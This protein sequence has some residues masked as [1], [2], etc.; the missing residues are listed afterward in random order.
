M[1]NPILSIVIPVFNEADVLPAFLPEIAEY[2]QSNDFVLI[3]VD[4]ASTDESAKLLAG[5]CQQSN[6]TL[7]RHKVNRGYGGALKTGIKAC[8]T[9]YVVTMDADGQH[10]PVDA[11]RLLEFGLAKGADMVVGRRQ[12]GN[13]GLYRAIGRKMIRLLAG[14]LV[15]L[16]IE[17][18]NSGMKLYRTRLAQ[19]YLVLCPDGMSFSDI[20]TLVFVHRNNLVLEHDINVRA[21][22]GGKST[23]STRTALETVFEILNIVAMFNPG[24]IFLP[25]GAGFIL[26]GLVWGLPF[27]IR[28]E[29]VSVGTMLL[30]VFGLIFFLVAIVAEQMAQL[31]RG[32][33][34][35]DDIE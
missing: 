16:P 35:E 28:D 26:F 21:R 4:D 34:Q 5:F 30:L 17:D 1:A 13:S 7:L 33:I 8:Q 29:G 19:G 6:S 24:R 32:Q 18:L 27:I 25:L 22:A 12:S 14:T 20:I 23:I 2:A 15:S 3:F 10:Q 11:G 9:E 31:R